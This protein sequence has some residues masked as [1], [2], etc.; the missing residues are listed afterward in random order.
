MDNVRFLLN[1]DSALTIEFSKEINEQVN[2]KIRN[3]AKKI[4]D[5]HI[6]GVS[7][8]VPTFCSMTVFFNPLLISEKKL[9][10]KLEKIIKKYKES[11]KEKKRV[12][13]IP[14]CYEGKFAPDID[15]VSRITCLSKEEVINIHSAKNYLI[16]MLGFLPGFPYLGGMDEKIAVPRLNTPRTQIPAGSVGI[17][18]IQTGIYP[19]SSPGGW[20]LIG[21]TPIKLYDPKRENP[22]LFR[23]GD[24]IRFV[25][26]NEK[27]FEEIAESHNYVIQIAEVD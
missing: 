15:D 16:Y 10:K 17:G 18:G 12:F 8:V 26:I 20:R 27:E 5:K 2:R 1:G 23:A 13:M 19:T 21:R 24:Y 11:T 9:S 7:E 4:E 3:I 22:I 6:K 25:P 14:V